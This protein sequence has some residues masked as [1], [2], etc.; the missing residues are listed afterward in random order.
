M[1]VTGETY[2][3]VRQ[4]LKGTNLSAVEIVCLVQR[5]LNALP[6]PLREN[7]SLLSQVPQT[8]LVC[9]ARNGAV[10]H[11]KEQGLRCIVNM[12]IHS[13]REPFQLDRDRRPVNDLERRID[14]GEEDAAHVH[15][16]IPRRVPQR[17]IAASDEA[18]NEPGQRGRRLTL[19][20]C[21]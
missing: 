21:G 6:V 14:V 13:V 9:Q 8:S 12:L 19:I 18:R 2:H 11:G 3:I 15:D 4:R 7:A 5:P 17:L 20:G 10:V 1:N 16:V